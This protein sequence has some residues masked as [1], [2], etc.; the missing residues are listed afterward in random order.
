MGVEVGGT[1][2]DKIAEL[3]GE[4][5]A[6]EVSGIGYARHSGAGRGVGVADA[7]HEDCGL[8]LVRGEVGLDAAEGRFG[9]SQGRQGRADAV[10]DSHGVVVLV[11]SIRSDEDAVEP[12]AVPTVFKN[13]AAEF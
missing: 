13:R 3:A 9:E 10:A 1:H 8:V 12:A 7:R 6:D 11:L 4:L 2:G 5:A